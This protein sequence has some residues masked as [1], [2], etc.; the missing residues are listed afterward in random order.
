MQLLNPATLNRDM[1]FGLL[2]TEVESKANL[3]AKK[4]FH[5][6]TVWMVDSQLQIYKEGDYINS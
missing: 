1:N 4:Y 3:V 6:I 5:I 2:S